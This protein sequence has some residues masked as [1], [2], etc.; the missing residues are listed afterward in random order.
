MNNIA[1]GI[2]KS[3]IHTTLYSFGSFTIFWV[4]VAS[5]ADLSTVA[6]WKVK[7]SMFIFVVIN[8]IYELIRED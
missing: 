1:K 7:T 6:D 4:I 5:V 2:L 8:V 3:I